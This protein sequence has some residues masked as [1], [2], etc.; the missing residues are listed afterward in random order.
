MN[1][2]QNNS[3]SLAF[4]VER[5]YFQKRYPAAWWLATCAREPRVSV[6]ARLPAMCRGKHIVSVCEMSG[7]GREALKKLSSPSH[8]A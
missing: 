7:G 8:A 6:P 3:E 4:V 5:Y 2:F 1:Y